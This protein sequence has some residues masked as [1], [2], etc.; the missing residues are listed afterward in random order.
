MSTQIPGLYIMETEE[1]GRGV[2][3]SIPISKGDIIESAPVIVF[4]DKDRQLLHKTLLH[5]Y[6]FLWESEGDQEYEAA[7]ALGYGSLY[8]HSK[9]PNTEFIPVFDEKVIEFVAIRDIE[10]GEEIL[11]EYDEGGNSAFELWF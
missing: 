6:Y 4:D 7:V 9:E 8:N 2:Y 3:T 1:K 10:A 11:I 5:D